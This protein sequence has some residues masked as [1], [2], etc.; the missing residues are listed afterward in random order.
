M[1]EFSLKKTRQNVLRA[2]S[3]IVRPKTSNLPSGP[4]KVFKEIPHHNY[5]LIYMLLV[6]L[7]DFR[8]FGPFEKLTYAIPLEH[9]GLLYGINYQK[10]GMRILYSENGDPEAVFNALKKGMKAAKPYYLWRA[11]QASTTA[12]LNLVSKCP[13]LWE[14][15][16]YL[17]EKSK[18]LIERYET[19]KDVTVVEKGFTEG[20]SE[21]TT[22]KYPAH[23]LLEQGRWIHEAAVDAFFAWCEQTLVH[24]AVLLGKLTN[25]KEIADLLH[26]NFSQ[27][28]N[29]VLDLAVSNDKAVYDDIASLRTELRNYVAHGSFGKDGST[30]SFHTAVG[31]V[32]LKVLDGRSSAGFSF[33]IDSVRDWKDDYRRIDEFV[34]Q[35]WSN[36]R[37]PAQLYI[38][39]GFP[40]IL[41]YSVDGTYARAM[42]SE[43]EMTE[44]ISHLGRMMDD[45]AN[46][47]F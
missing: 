17:R 27:K 2:I 5:Y 35:L 28:C 42:Q 46:M 29:L 26:G 40:C 23:E 39:T 24:V 22:Y 25:G 1:P 21:W 44:F 4:V 10:S 36:G 18:C 47:D 12:D 16:Q 30:F 3:P 33:G 20:G 9:E 15:Y 31:S 43:S 38:E 7:L 45:A 41:T 32:P 8:Y 13:M 19:E 14:K 34:S 6:D 11:E 37:V